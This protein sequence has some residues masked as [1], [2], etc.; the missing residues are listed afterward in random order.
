MENVC[1]QILETAQI[2]K[3]NEKCVWDIKKCMFLTSEYNTRPETALME[4]TLV[5]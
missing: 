3:L 5:V 1:M 2:S 4:N